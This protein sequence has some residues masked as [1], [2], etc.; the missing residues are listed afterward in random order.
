MAATDV[1]FNAGGRGLAR[2]AADFVEALRDGD[3][4]TAAAALATSPWANQADPN[5]A[6]LDVILTN[7]QTF[8]QDVTEAVHEALGPLEVEVP[9]WSSPDTASDPGDWDVPGDVIGQ[10]TLADPT[11]AGDDDIGDV[12]YQEAPSWDGGQLGD[13]GAPPGYAGDGY[14]GGGYGDESVGEDPGEFGE[15]GS[16]G[17]GQAGGD[18]ESGGQFGGGDGGYDGEGGYGGYGDEGEDDGEGAGDSG[19][20]GGD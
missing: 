17:G 18:T 3:L 12:G 4:D 14:S 11:S 7:P 1:A 19:E 15:G 10:V 13:P 9:D 16:F 8:V 6:E 2:S 20:G 5:R